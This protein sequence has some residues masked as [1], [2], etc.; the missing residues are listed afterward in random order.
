MLDRETILHQFPKMS[1][2]ELDALLAII[3]EKIELETNKAVSNK[4]GGGEVLAYG[5]IK[6]I[7]GG[8][9]A[10][11]NVQILDSYNIARIEEVSQVTDSIIIFRIWFT[12]SLK[13]CNY[14]PLISAEANGGGTELFG[15]Y[16]KEVNKFTFDFTTLDKTRPE[17]TEI[18]I[19]VYGKSS[20]S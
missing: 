2:E 9:N 10:I 19:F 16:G 3:D 15:V 6:L 13:N 4:L 11:S 1:P 17:I 8:D 20:T 7:Y 18:N 5:F 12:N 14:I